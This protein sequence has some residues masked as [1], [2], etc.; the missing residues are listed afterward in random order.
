MSVP[1][2]PIGLT[3]FSGSIKSCPPNP[4]A[5]RSIVFTK[6][7]NLGVT[8]GAA[9]EILIPLSNFYIPVGEATRTSFTLPKKTALVTEIHKL[10]LGGVDTNGEVKF[11]ALMPNYGIGSTSNS[12]SIE[13]AM[14]NSIEE[15][16]L[17][18]IP[19]VGPDGNTSFNF[20]QVN[21]IDFEWGKYLSYDNTGT[22]SLLAATNGGL[23][24][25][26]GTKCKLWNTL[27]SNS[28]T[29]YLN[30]IAVD[31]DNIAWISTNSGVVAFKNESFEVKFNTTN[32]ILPSNNVTAIEPFENKLTIA[33]DKGLSVC[34]K[35]GGNFKTFTIYNT[36]F[37]KHELIKKVKVAGDPIIFAGTTGGAYFMDSVTS[38]WGRYALNSLTVPGWSGSDDIQDMAVY[39]QNVYFAT[40]NGLVT[41][42][43]AGLTS[44]LSQY[45]GITAT[46]IVGGSGGDG[47]LTNN[48]TSLRVQGNDLFVGHEN[49]GISI[50]NLTTDDWYFAST[51][52]ELGGEA[53]TC[54]VSNFLASGS[55]KTLFTGNAISSRVVKLNVDTSD[56]DNA[57]GE[58]DLTDLMLSVT[59]RK[60]NL[61]GSYF[62]DDIQ[63]PSNQ[64][65]WFVFSKP[66]S[67]TAIFDFLSLRNGLG[68]TGSVVN[69]VTEQFSSCIVAAQP[70]D[71]NNDTIELNKG[72][73]YNLRLAMG[74]TGVDGSFITSGLNVGFYTEDVVP[75]LG[76]NKLGKML[77]LSGSDNN[78]IEGIYLRNPQS[79]DITI[80]SLIG[81]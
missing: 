58:G 73:G 57:P 81:N 8:N 49:G 22:G 62:V 77:I 48:Y 1:K 70:V 47:P 42:P 74:A 23:L 64:I 51:V 36:P 19:Q 21:G 2:Q 61:D 44:S 18:N 5:I 17:A 32:S 29:D 43:Y 79:T 11:I 25:W 26:D 54:L 28:T 37:L 52:P 10:N 76:W 53:V 27:N 72:V 59:G 60:I 7:D 78:L 9:T 24:Q 39:G 46:T 45:V 55:P 66:V 75:I 71:I 33:T 15:G 35:G 65:F 6:C 41:I 68:G 31:S 34:E 69:L 63:Y 3:N 14:V 13:W 16:E 30:S 50:L 80:V 12:I 38:T 67:D 20:S 40:T 4:D 56:S